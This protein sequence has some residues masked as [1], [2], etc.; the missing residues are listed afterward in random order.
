MNK[1]PAFYS[2]T[3]KNPCRWPSRHWPRSLAILLLAQGWLGLIRL[4]AE[5]LRTADQVR[6]LSPAEAA[7]SLP[8]RLRGVVT[9][10]DAGLYSRFIQDAT[11]GIYFTESTNLPPLRAGQEVELTGTTSPGEYAPIV[12]TT[13]LQVLGES[14]LPPARKVTAAELVGGS[15]D[16]QMVE[17]S[18]IVRSVRFEEE[19]QNFLIDVMS[20]GERFTAYAKTLPVTEPGALVDSV[21][22][23]RGVCSTLFNRLRQLLG[24]RLLVSRPE[25]VVF[26]TRPA[27]D[28]FAIAAQ[29]INSL[30]RFAPQGT[31]GHRVK[32]TGTV[33]CQEP[34]R[35]VFIQDE[36]E[37]LYVQTRQRTALQPG[38]VVEVLGFPAKGEYTPML[39]DAI[40]RKSTDGKPPVAVEL[41]VDEVMRGT[42]DCRLIRIKGN[43][44]ERTQRGREQ[45]LVLEN[46]GVTFHAYFSQDADITGIKNFL[47]GSE[48]VLSGI[49]LVERGSSWQAGESW[50]VKSFRLLLPSLA[51]VQVIAEPPWWTQPNKLRLAGIAGL[52]ALSG[53]LL[54]DVLR[55]RKTNLRK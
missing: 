45:F 22:R 53:L 55:R 35:A 47:N 46:G 6:H 1:Q 25:D 49:C 17:I 37:G 52:V 5:E 12:V 29:P 8:V 9:F 48:L 26:E 14:P 27:S 50:R 28:P 42:H 13:G 7:K 11:A 21:I 44:L 2:V 15:L 36:A 51:S 19:T 18:G 31:Y 43:L 3:P 34:G 39:Q 10:S 41:D 32:V 54:L 24:F 20:G 33:S 40:Y 16:S 30:L 38:D 4:P 23:V